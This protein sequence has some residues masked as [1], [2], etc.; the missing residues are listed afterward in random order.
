M[1]T[2]S[3][4]SRD[5]AT[6]AYRSYNMTQNKRD[7]DSNFKKFRSPGK[8]KIKQKTLCPCTRNILWNRT[9][10][11]SGKIPLASN[12]SLSFFDPF[13][14]EARAP[15]THWLR[16]WMELLAVVEVVKTNFRITARNW[17][18][19]SYHPDKRFNKSAIPSHFICKTLNKISCVVIWSVQ[20]S[21]CWHTLTYKTK[22]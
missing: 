20:S 5:D 13:I 7:R 21:L 8:W 14:S 9:C 16:V 22:L 19:V 3:T 1:H 12:L 2:N 11:M 18:Q 15:N 10:E 4:V 6:V 17:K